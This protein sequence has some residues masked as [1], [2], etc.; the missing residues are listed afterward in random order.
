MAFVIDHK[1]LQKYPKL[2]SFS[3]LNNRNHFVSDIFVENDNTLIKASILNLNDIINRLI[4]IPNH[5]N[6]IK[7]TEI[8]TIYYKDVDDR[9]MDEPLY[10]SI[11][12]MKYLK[13]AK[14]L[15]ELYSQKLSFT[16]KLHYCKQLFNSLKFLHQYI[17]LGDIH[18]EN[19]LIDNQNAYL[20]DLDYAKSKRHPF[21]YISCYYYINAFKGM[22]NTK[23][24]DIVK[25]YL[26][27]LSFFLEINLNNYIAAFGYHN[28]LDIFLNYP[29]P[30]EIFHF[31]QMSCPAHKL[32]KLG[33]EAYNFEQ[34]ITKDLEELKSAI[35]IFTRKKVK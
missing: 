7:P 35:D 3:E 24:T 6:V 33:D 22:G 17:V 21:Q 14:T 12:K 28:F 9:E 31:F 32:A 34:F 23:Y 5:P 20:I 15:L 16:E 4:A 13:N 29:L 11:Y 2:D 8:G 27:C 19:I 30:P 18:S 1:D 25:L 10:Q 26:E